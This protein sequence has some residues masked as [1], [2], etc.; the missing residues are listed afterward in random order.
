[1][2]FTFF[3]RD[4]HI[5]ELV[6]KHALPNLAG[7][8]SVKV[9]DAGCAMGQEPYTLAILLAEHM[10]YFAFKNLEI[11]ATDIEETS[12]F[13]DIV[14]NGVYPADEL[15]RIPS[16]LREKYFR[17]V[18]GSG[19]LQVIDALRTRV[20]YGRHDLL[21]LAPVGSQFSVILC[22]NV[23]LHFQQDERIEVI[24]M[25]HRS[26]SPG[27]YF[28]T[29]QTQKMPEELEHLFVKVAPDGQIFRRAE[30]SA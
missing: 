3:F 11:H 4:L 2:A 5:M 20:K 23:L 21:S 19:S 12:N 28:A 27:G 10:G 18:N 22:K 6:V 17:P 26:L 15:Q 13:G 30:G 16:D 1:V 8:S 25:F 29:E 14:R 7:R 24:K 9:W